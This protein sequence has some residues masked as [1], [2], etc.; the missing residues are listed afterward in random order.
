MAELLGLEPAR[1]HHKWA[2]PAHGGSD[3]LH[4][5]DGAGAGFF[6]WGACGRAYSNV[7]LAAEVWR[8]EP[9]EACVQLAGLLGIRLPERRPRRRRQEARRRPQRSR[10]TPAPRR[11]AK[12]RQNGAQAAVSE[13]GL[14]QELREL[15]YVP[16][17]ASEMYGGLLA[18]L[19]L[20][21]SGADYL[22]GRGFDPDAAEA[23]GFRS[24]DGP[25]DWRRLRDRLAESYLPAELKRAGLHHWPAGIDRSPALVLPYRYQGEAIALRFRRLEAGEPKLVNLAGVPAPALPFNADA[26][27]GLEGEELHV[28]EGELNSYS[29]RECG[30]RAIGLPGAGSW[31]TE[32]TPRVVRAGRVV[33]WYDSDEA[34]E[35]GER[36]LADALQVALG[37][38]WLEERGQ[39]VELGSG[40]DANDLH[41][42]GRLRELAERAPWRLPHGAQ[43]TPCNTRDPM[44]RTRPHGANVP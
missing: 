14:L 40:Q 26:L 17:G 4:A 36:K 37:S 43:V 32:W 33:A 22:R 41:R 7:D 1:E 6:C 15:G 21:D 25:E 31:R 20:T 23:Y 24:V 8:V 39:A 30:L 12:A 35:R 11:A 10:R 16:S 42:E 28:A 44:Q 3:S 5:Y 18:E 2:C 9:A 29:L 34:G 19:E 13:P 38:R 27:D